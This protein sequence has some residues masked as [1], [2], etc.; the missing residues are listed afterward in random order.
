MVSKLFHSFSLPSNLVLDVLI[1]PWL[2]EDIGRGDR[3]TQA[4]MV[5]GSQRNS[6]TWI[7]KETGI[8]A[9]L[10]IAA[11]VFQLL[12]SQVEFEV[13]I[14]DGDRKSTRLNSSHRNTSRMPSSA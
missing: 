2:L 1:R 9:G 4:L 8:I 14:K 12:D 10:P 3:V 5:K 13:C 11:R 6:A 7:A